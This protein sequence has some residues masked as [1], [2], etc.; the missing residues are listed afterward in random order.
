MIVI[1]YIGK[2]GYLASVKKEDTKLYLEAIC[3]LEFK[4][5]IM[6]IDSKNDNG[7]EAE[8]SLINT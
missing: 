4:H 2:I 1:N 6:A 8:L 3:I 5:V 7:I